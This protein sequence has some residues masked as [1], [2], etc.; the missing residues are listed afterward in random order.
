M[1]ATLSARYA[2]RQQPGI[3]EPL[4]QQPSKAREAVLVFVPVDVSQRMEAFE[5]T[6]AQKIAV[7]AD[8]EVDDLA[9]VFD[10]ARPAAALEARVCFVAQTRPAER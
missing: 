9:A 8:H 2:L 4:Q 5:I 10:P 7:G 6:F 1:A 3:V